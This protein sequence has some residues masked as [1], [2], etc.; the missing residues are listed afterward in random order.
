L[1]RRTLAPAEVTELKELFDA[2]PAALELA[3]RLLNESSPLS[4]AY[5][6]ADAEFARI[7]ARINQ[8]LN[9]QPQNASS[10]VSNS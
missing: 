5:L 9:G 2:L 3:Q 4:A 6:A 10:T 8:I 1:S 7:I